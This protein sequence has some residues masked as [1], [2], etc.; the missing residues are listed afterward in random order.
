VIFRRRAANGE[1]QQHDED[2]FF[3]LTDARREIPPIAVMNH[4]STCELHPK[5]DPNAPV[6]II[7]DM[8]GP[9][10]DNEPLSQPAYAEVRT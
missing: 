6:E 4:T 3:V 8:P 7:C 5:E 1:T 2:P 9:N 10:D